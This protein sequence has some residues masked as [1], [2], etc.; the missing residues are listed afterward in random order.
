M[1]FV[2]VPHPIGMLPEEEVQ[3]KI[4]KAFADIVKA[5]LEWKPGAA[6]AS[7]QAKPYPAHTFKFTGTYADVNN[8]FSKRKWSLSLPIVPPTVDAVKEMLKG[9]TRDPAEVLWVVPPRQ[10]ILTVELAAAIGVMAGAKPEHMPLLLATIEAMN[11]PEA[12]WQG[13]TTTTAPTVP[14]LI[15]SGPIVEKFKLNDSTGTCGG[16]N[17]VTNAL[18]YFVNLIGDVVGGSVPPVLDKSTHGTSADL[19]ATVFVENAKEN[20]WKKTFAEDAGFNASD[21]VVTLVTC[22]LGGSNI[23]HT[24]TTGKRLLNTLSAGIL[25]SATGISSCYADVK[26]PYSIDNKVSFTFLFLCPEHADTIYREFPV[27]EEVRKYV[28]ET[29]AMPLKFYAPDV[30]APPAELGKVTEDTLLRR[31]KYPESIHIVVTGGP[32]KQSQIWSPFPQVVKPV[33]VKIAE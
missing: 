25:G 1:S 15:I 5:A 2:V 20:P 8:M 4:D 33:S 26:K 32:G 21:S 28:V 19:V 3:Q 6:V 27:K 29:A 12:A 10:G 31:F 17:P 23:D 24:S 11:N 22:Y 16:E 14:I 30:C 7:E 9:T 13:T 18:G